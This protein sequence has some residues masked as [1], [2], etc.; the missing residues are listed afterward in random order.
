[1]F[2]CNQRFIPVQLFTGLPWAAVTIHM[3]LAS[4]TWVATLRLRLALTERGGSE[5]VQPDVI[6]LDQQAV[7]S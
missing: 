7:A 1:M 4:L 3:L 2:I 6:E 5:S